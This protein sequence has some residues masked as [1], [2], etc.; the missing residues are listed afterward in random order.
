M[1]G[2]IDGMRAAYEQAPDERCSVEAAPM[3]QALRKLFHDVN[4]SE[5]T[6]G[7]GAA[8]FAFLLIGSSIAAAIDDW[9]SKALRGLKM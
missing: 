2:A 6:R 3:F 1:R 7:S 5:L 4:A 8:T 9:S